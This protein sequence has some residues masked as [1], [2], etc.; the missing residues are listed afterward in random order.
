[1]QI[2][3]IGIDLGKTACDV[4]ARDGRG[5]VVARRRLSRAGW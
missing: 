4:V 5:K 2:K 3:T 1:M